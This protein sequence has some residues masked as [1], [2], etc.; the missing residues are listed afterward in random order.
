MGHPFRGIQGEASHAG[1]T[2]ARIGGEATGCGA[3]EN[4]IFTIARYEIF[5][6]V[7]YFSGDQVAFFDG[8]NDAGNASEFT[9]VTAPFG[10]S[11][12]VE[13]EIP[14][15]FIQPDGSFDT[16]EV[17]FTRVTVIR[18]GDRHDFDVDSGSKIKETGGSEVKEAGDTF[19][20]TNDDVG[21]P[22][23]GPFAGLSS[24]K[25]VFSTD[26]TFATGQSTTIDR[27]QATDNNKDG[28]TSDGGE[29]A[30]AQFN[31][32]QANTP[33]CFAAGTLIETLLGPRKVEV[34]RPGDYVLTRD[35]GY[36]RVLWRRCGTQAMDRVARDEKPVLIKAGSLGRGRPC[37]DLIVSP[38]H[39]ILV[40][41]A[42]QLSDVFPNEVLAP[43]KGLTGRCGIRHMMG[44][45]ELTWV[46]FACTRHEIVQ[47][48]GCWS[49]S[50]LLGKVAQSGLTPDQRRE[51]L[52][53]LAP[54]EDPDFL[55]GPAA[56][57][58]LTV[59]QTR[60]YAKDA[61]KTPAAVA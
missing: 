23:S 58:C 21:P 7:L 49:E 47:A 18:G 4:E 43:A 8:L 48:N 28:D 42:G 30:D 52:S 5:M 57:R 29:S 2:R 41:E 44:R 22:G 35:H 53:L 37:Q 51:L 60:R 1:R 56:R 33:T 32:G 27:T 19:F 54:I 12:T 31:A 24:G 14:D 59:T 25:L 13:I 20:T 3:A 16:D 10:P 9:G 39:R 45:R 38:Q 40:G 34:I 17:Q 11:D 26:S 50:L 61:V 46:H 6:A 36:Q 15:Q 55:N